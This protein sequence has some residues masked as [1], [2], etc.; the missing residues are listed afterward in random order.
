VQPLP[1]R[2]GLLKKG[3]E[4][5]SETLPTAQE[6]STQAKSDRQDLGPEK[7]PSSQRAS[8]KSRSPVSGQRLISLYVTVS[9]R[10]FQGCFDHSS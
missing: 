1:K 2:N 4:K 7:I 5:D 10:Y 3:S 8:S 9:K 6:G